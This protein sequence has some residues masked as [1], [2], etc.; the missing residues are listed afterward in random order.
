[1]RKGTSMDVSQIAHVCHEANRALQLV[2]GDPAPSPEWL[3][4]PEWQRQSA[5]EGVSAAQAGLTAEELHSSWC[6]AKTEG[7]W[8]FGPVKDPVAKTHPCLVPYDELPDEQ[9]AKDH[10]FAAIVT[11]L[12]K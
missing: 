7:G 5:I 11:A 4:A 9:K 2:S 3:D 10:V 8:V 12:S 6:T 1:M